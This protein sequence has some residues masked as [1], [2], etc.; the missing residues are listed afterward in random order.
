MAV[1]NRERIVEL[2]RVGAADR[3]AQRPRCGRCAKAAM[4]G[5]PTSTSPSPPRAARPT[6]RAWSGGRAAASSGPSTSRSDLPDRRRGDRDA[7]ADRR[8]VRSSCA[9]T[10]SALELA[11][12][13]D[14]VERIAATGRVASLIGVE[15]GHSIGSSLGALRILAGLGAGYLTLTHINDTP[16]ADSAT[17]DARARRPHH[18]R[19]G[20]RAR[21]EPPAGCSWTSR[22]CPTTRCGRRS[23][24]RRHRCSSRTRRRARSATCTRN[25][26]TT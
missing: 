23:R 25:V 15:G 7:R 14:D 24:S 10:P 8:A 18:V 1:Q 17:G 3:R 26:P 19:R 22:T 6:C 2:L 5:E 9:R 20:G 11:R 12:T 13:A 16:W 21:A 4:D